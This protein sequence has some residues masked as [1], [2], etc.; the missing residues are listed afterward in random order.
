VPA[1]IIAAAAVAASTA[2]QIAT[3]AAQQFAR[4]GLIEGEM[5]PKAEHGIFVGPSHA[6]GGINTR[7]SGRRVN[8]EGGEYFERLRN[9][10]TVVINKRS[11]SRFRDA[12]LGQAGR[13]YPGKLQTL[14]GINQYGGGVPL[15]AMG[16]L[17]PTMGNAS[18]DPN[19][20]VQLQLLAAS[21][22]KLS[23]RVPVLTV[24]SYD[25]VNAR[26]NQVK[27]LQGL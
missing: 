11:T 14:S 21:I 2:V 6:G 9:G 27:T 8:V 18:V 24:Q 23:N 20:N 15:F 26:A 25:T 4:G 1:G 13:D 19:Q 22:D 5:T 3:I 16:G 10:S 7:L 12:L 17:V